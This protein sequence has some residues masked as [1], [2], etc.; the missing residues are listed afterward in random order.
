M[1][2]TAAVLLCVLCLSL[3]ACTREDSGAY[4]RGMAALQQ[5]DY[6]TA[7]EEFQHAASGD[8]REAE[9]YRGEGIIYLRQQDY[10]H[11]ITLFGLSLDSMKH[12][13][14]QFRRDVLYYQAEAYIGNG[15]DRDAEAIYT[16]LIEE[17]G[18]AQ[19]YFLRG[20]G[21]L[22]SGDTEGA[23]E[24][25]AGALRQE[26]SY[27]M[28]M[29][30][31]RAYAAVNREADGADYP[32]Q[33]LSLE[34][35]GGEDYYLQAQ[36]YDYLGD[37]AKAEEALTKAVQEGCQEALPMLGKLYLE[38]GDLSGARR[39]YQDFLESG[40]RPAAAYN[41]L[42]LCDIQQEEYESALDNIR[43]GI[44]CQDT[45]VMRD[46]LFNEIVVYEKQL[47]FQTAKEKMQEYLKQYPK[48]E[49]A[50]RENEFLQSR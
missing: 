24:D 15:Q 47:D 35:A 49:E 20:S 31:Y 1:R 2:R 5:G 45:E 46:L 44:A 23:A 32:E 17:D 6:D 43:Q 39:L 48:D 3:G 27:E 36:V 10:G 14:P 42:A 34:P 18:D 16:E 11:A 38:T 37:Y 19:A 12:S 13:N 7:M 9:A 33:A 30:I 21:K 40:E 28:Y 25:F 4:D 29:K 41:G 8:G 26:N 22:N 50:L